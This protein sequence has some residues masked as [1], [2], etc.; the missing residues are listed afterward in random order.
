MQAPV[1]IVLGLPHHGKTAARK[2]LSEL[3]FL[4]G[5]ST[6]TVIYRFLALRRKVTVESLLAQPKEI[7]RPELI[8]AG[9][10]LVG[11]L[12]R[13]LAPA[14]DPEIEKVVYRIPSALVRTLYL[15]GFN[16]IDGVR[17][18]EELTDTIRHL[19]WNGIRTLVLWIENPAEPR[20][21]DN[22]EVTREDADEVVLNLGTL[23]DLKAKLKEILE[24][25]FGKQ[26]DKPTPLPVYDSPEAAAAAHKLAPD[27]NVAEL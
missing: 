8:E 4:K 24:K 9:D 14:D 6:S 7:L 11:K 10:Y 1:F 13:I 19:H 25:H 22:T 2:I 12:D 17:R 18:K 3:T 5:E 20:I 23:D 16:I 26:P 21:A 15:N 27:K